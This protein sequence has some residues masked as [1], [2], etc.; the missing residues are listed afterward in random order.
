MESTD[1]I[2][3][4]VE[5]DLRTGKHDRVV[6]RFPPEPNGYL[7]IGHAKSI[8]LNFGI[9]EQYG[10]TCHLRFDDT[11]PEKEDE[12]FV[13]AI[14]RDVRWLGF[15]WGQN[16]FHASDYFERLYELA[17]LLV[18]KG[19]A[20]VCSLSEEAVR[21][22]RG[23]L[24]EPGRESPYRSRTVE[25]NLELL[26][27]MRAGRFEDG[28]HTL[29]AKI[30]MA[31]PN[32]LM[33]DP[34]LY[35]IRHAQHHRTGDAWCIYPMYDY[36]H[37]LSDSIEG[38]THSICTLEFENNRELY[39]WLVEK[40]DVPCV[41]RQYEFARLNLTYT[42]MSKRKLLQLVRERHVVG[43]DDPRMPTLAGYR[44]RGV[45]PEA[46][47][48]LCARVGVARSNSTVELE[49]LEHLIRA[50]LNHRAPRVMAVLR[51]LEVVIDNLPPGET[52][53]LD[54]PYWPHDVP[55]E[56]SR[57]VPLG[58]TVLIE[59]E[60]FSDDPPAGWKRLV[61]GGSVRLRYGCVIRCDAVERDEQGEIT[62]L[63][64]TYDPESIGGGAGRGPKPR[65]IIHWVSAAHGLPCE[66]RLYDRLFSVERPEEGDFLQNLSDRSLEVV[67]GVVEPSVADDPSDQRYQFERQGSFWRD[68]VSSRPEALVFN[69][70]VALRDSFQK[71]IQGEEPAPAPAAGARPGADRTRPA[72]RSKAELQERLLE[73][74][75][76]LQAAYARYVALGV[77]EG[78][79]RIIATTD[80]L[81]TFF[82]EAQ[83][84][85]DAPRT[86]S[87]WVVNEVVR[88]LKEE[89]LDALS[90]SPAALG[91]LVAQVDDGS[92]P[93]T[94]GKQVFADLV[95][96]GGLPADAIARLGL[97]RVARVDLDAI[98]R[99]VIAA[100]PD[101]AARYRDGKTALIGF[102]VGQ[103][104][105][106]AQGAADAQAVRAALLQQL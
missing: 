19:L 69:R 90:V 84:V 26:R 94:A 82:E 33:R 12:E 15:D 91:A 58:R 52:V 44:R 41:P 9:A 64:C 67:R 8:C 47:R 92:L 35:R 87:K 17:E 14:Q 75:P 80:G 99:A 11:N 34:L 101:E 45:T 71:Q 70:V 76:A 54:A 79:A 36:A 95:V 77:D 18:R 43:W 22:Y 89:T 23:T 37:C 30:D 62:R 10:G 29:R 50:D 83:A 24:T 106:Q 103:V 20:Y 60:D 104:M 2:R 105:R 73:Q 4:I 28:A 38:I 72:R 59:R 86:V 88:E 40:T 31:A 53:W 13:D 3:V 48:E 74:N 39:D 97:D 46:I 81:A 98:V 1:F 102:F 65:G 51:P 25:E 68:P 56:G 5:E 27:G 61:E 21:A 55:R 66:I 100:H 7:H 57:R 78:D 16:L 49:L 63:R 32:M 42:V 85:H 93:A 96:H 6:T